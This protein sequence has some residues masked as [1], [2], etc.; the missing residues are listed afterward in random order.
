L[1]EELLKRLLS[2]KEG[3]AFEDFIL[4]LWVKSVFTLHWDKLATQGD[5]LIILQKIK[6]FIQHKNKHLDKLLILK[7]KLHMLN[8]L[9]EAKK[10]KSESL[11]NKD[12]GLKVK[13]E[14][15]YKDN[16]DNFD[17]DE[18]EKSED[19]DSEEDEE[20]QYIDVKKRKM[21]EADLE[22]EDG[23]SVEN[24]KMIDDE[25]SSSEQ[26]IEED[27]NDE[28]DDLSNEYD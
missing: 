5:K 6:T 19:E 18:E 7:G 10:S 3:P 21:N 17:M 16:D 22:S 28:K 25:V 14:L 20:I 8:T 2:P 26:N 23:E 12:S 1:L 9:I 27:D 4:L 13:R 15:V 11:H 24:E